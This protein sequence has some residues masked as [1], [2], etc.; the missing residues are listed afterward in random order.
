MDPVTAT[1]VAVVVMVIGTVCLL[2]IVTKKAY[3]H[4]WD[5]EEL[6]DSPT[7]A[8]DPRDRDPDHV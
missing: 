4:K 8:T 5:T 2:L 1:I 3:T 7:S 6:S